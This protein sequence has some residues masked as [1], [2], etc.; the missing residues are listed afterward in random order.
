MEDLTT[1]QIEKQPEYLV[2]PSMRLATAQF[3]LSW[4]C[5]DPVVL[6]S[7]AKRELP[8][9]HIFMAKGE[10]HVMAIEAPGALDMIYSSRSEFMLRGE[11]QW[12]RRTVR[13][14]VIHTAELLLPR[15]L[16][17]LERLHGLHSSG[18]TVKRLRKCVLGQCDSRRHI[19]LSPMIVILPERL[20]DEVILHEMAHLK[21]MNHGPRFWA[22]LSTLLGE[23][24]K[25]RKTELDRLCGSY[26]PL[27]NYLMKP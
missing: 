20:M 8:D 9:R 11:Q 26:Y 25:A 4:H 5:I 3:R 18:V 7:E 24:A 12:L 15:R 2:N 6:V 19:C 21:Q 10:C 23:D 17:H 13:D 1:S 16:A 14:A 22:L 27:F